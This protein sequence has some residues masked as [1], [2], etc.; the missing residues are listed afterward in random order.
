MSDELPVPEGTAP[1]GSHR[2]PPATA[3]MIAILLMLGVGTSVMR[4][5]VPSRAAPSDVDL[6]VPDWRLAPD[7]IVALAK[8]AAARR[9]AAP[10]ADKKEVQ[11]LVQAFEAFNAADLLHQGDPRSRALKDA[12]AEYQQWAKTAYQYLGQS[13]FMGLGQRLGDEFSAALK[14]GE[15]ATVRRLSGSF[16]HTMRATGL[17]DSAGRPRTSQGWRIAGLGF[18]THWCLAV[19]ALGPIDELLTV[20][21]RIA[22]LRWKL[23]QNPL[24]RPERRIAVG[25]A[26]RQLGSSY[27]VAHALGARAAADGDWA[28]AAQYYQEA[29]ALAPDDVS[30][31]ANAALA[32]ARTGR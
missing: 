10:D 15:D 1:T 29:A 8:A 23:G 18:M 9:A 21:E 5:A 25:H 3:A 24:L 12:H 13:A 27:P 28:A 14:R 11:A 30:L 16:R 22:L 7:E 17:I 31:R 2:I 4:I 26:L 19:T 6:S 20:T 32:Q